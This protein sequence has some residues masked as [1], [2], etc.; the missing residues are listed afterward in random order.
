MK[1]YLKYILLLGVIGIGAAYYM[2][3]KP[4]KNMEK[5]KAD[6]S[7]EASNLLTA[8]EEDESAANTKYLDKTLEIS[9]TV[10]ETRTDEEG[11]VSV[12]LET[13]NELSGVI[14]Q[15]DNLTTHKKTDFQAGEKVIFKGLC[16]GMLMDVIIVRCVQTNQ[17]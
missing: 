12:T 9:G 17:S 1:K 16:T 15:L 2:Y 10:K 11:M 3:N 4:H 5:A 13:G 8:F 7:I 6:Y 14:C